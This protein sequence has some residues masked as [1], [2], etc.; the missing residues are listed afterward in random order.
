MLND[1][2]LHVRMKKK[3]ESLHGNGKPKVAG[4]I[5]GMAKSDIVGSVSGK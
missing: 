5:E 1:L 2:E 4:D 3:D